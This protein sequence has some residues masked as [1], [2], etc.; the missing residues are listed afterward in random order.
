MKSMSEQ[1]PFDIIVNIKPK[2]AAKLPE[3]PFT[4]ERERFK[5]T[6]EKDIKALNSY[7]AMIAR[8]EEMQELQDNFKKIVMLPRL[9]GGQD[10]K[11]SSDKLVKLFNE[12]RIAAEKSTPVKPAIDT[13]VKILPQGG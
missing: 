5:P 13:T 11:E 8:G 2:V 3:Y 6:H 10:L 4:Y 1:I 7:L 9:E 12:R